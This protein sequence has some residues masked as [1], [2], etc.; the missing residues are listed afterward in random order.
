MT[1]WKR[2]FEGIKWAV[3]FITA[4]PDLL[5]KASVKKA[6]DFEVTEIRE[7][8]TNI[9]RTKKTKGDSV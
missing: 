8:L 2:I 9:K 4:N 3:R 5:G 1:K 6:P 7:T